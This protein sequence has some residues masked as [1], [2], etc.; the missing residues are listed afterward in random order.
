MVLNITVDIPGEKSNIKH[1][2]WIYKISSW[3]ERSGLRFTNEL[4][5]YN[6]I[7]E[8]LLLN[9]EQINISF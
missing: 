2:K 8:C 4:K 9:R 1:E 6:Q 5:T 7:N 3:V